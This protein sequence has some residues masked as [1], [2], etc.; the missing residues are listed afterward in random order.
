[1]AEWSEGR[2]WPGMVT[3]LYAQSLT[4]MSRAE[5]A[6]HRREATE[7]LDRGRREPWAAAAWMVSSVVQDLRARYG[8]PS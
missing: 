6:V 1:M 4:A 5:L 8:A 2:E 3:E 7:W